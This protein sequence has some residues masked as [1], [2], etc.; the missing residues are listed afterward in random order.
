M[1]KLDTSEPKAVGFRLTLVSQH[2]IVSGI[3]V[4]GLSHVLLFFGMRLRKENVTSLGGT[5]D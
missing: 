1:E 2:P 3:S 5:T 4:K